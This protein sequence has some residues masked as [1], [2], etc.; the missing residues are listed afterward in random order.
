M[1]S[2]NLSVKK[3]HLKTITEAVPAMVKHFIL[4]E[5]G[6]KFDTGEITRNRKSAALKLIAIPEF[7]FVVLKEF[8]E[9]LELLL[10]YENSGN[11][12]F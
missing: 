11:S 9:N 3:I 5:I 7:I 10:R 2:V 6:V 1:K 12:F 8:T 4:I